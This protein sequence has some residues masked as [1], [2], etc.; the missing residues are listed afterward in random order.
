MTWQRTGGLAKGLWDKGVRSIITGDL[1][2]EWYLYSIAHP[3]VSPRDITHNLERYYPIDVV[4]RMRRIYRTLPEDAHVED[5]E[6]LF[7]EI[8]SDGQVHL[9]VRLLVR[10]LHN[11]GFPVLRYEIRW[12]PEQLRPKGLVT[13]ATD[14]ALWFLHVPSLTPPQL[15]VATAWLDAIAAEIKTLDSD[16]TPTRGMKEKLTM[17]D[18]Q[19]IEWTTDSRWEEMMRLA[20]ILPGERHSSML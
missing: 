19:T 11:A 18:N 8:L 10:D 17:R 4:E 7:G 3:V 9:P 16:T 15:D 20:T 1:K 5:V 6:R 13:H 2:E 14:C 12:T